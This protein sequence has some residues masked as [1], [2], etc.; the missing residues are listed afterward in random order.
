MVTVR[1]YSMWICVKRACIFFGDVS[2]KRSEIRLDLIWS[3]RGCVR[4]PF[5][6]SVSSWVRWGGKRFLTHGMVVRTTW[7]PG[8][9]TRS[10]PV[11]SF[12]HCCCLDQGQH[13]TPPVLSSSSCREACTCSPMQSTA[14]YSP[15]VSR[16]GGRR[17]GPQVALP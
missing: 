11:R 12:R 14:F 4:I 16:D 15:T 9:S 3:Q 17:D 1:T 5:C 13:R 10:D 8:G 2:L 6:S 7:R